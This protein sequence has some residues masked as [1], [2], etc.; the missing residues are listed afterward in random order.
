VTSANIARILNIF[1]RKGAVAPG[2]DADLVVWD[3]AARK[4]ISAKNQL[5]RIDYNVFEGFACA[6]LPIATL[7]RGKIAWRDGDLRAEKGDGR[8]VERPAFSPVH[9]ANSTWKDLTAPRAV[10]RGAIVP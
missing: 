10:P 2:S 4:V 9:V 3:P 8:Y 7:S 5:S 1:P 6:G